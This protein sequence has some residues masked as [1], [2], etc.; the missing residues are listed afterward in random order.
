M[1]KHVAER[2]KNHPALFGFD[3]M[4]EPFPGTDGGK[5][6]RKL[7]MSIAK[8]VLTDKRCKKLWMLKQL[9]T[10]NAIKCLEPFNDPTLFR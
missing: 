6:F 2:F 3:L 9:I 8:T 1:W 5:V 7:I 4:N 10:G